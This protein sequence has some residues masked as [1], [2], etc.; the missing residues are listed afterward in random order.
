MYIRP[1]HGRSIGVGVNVGA[2]LG[3]WITATIERY[4]PAT[5]VYTVT[6]HLVQDLPHLVDFVK[7]KGRWRAVVMGREMTL[8][9]TPPVPV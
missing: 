5:L 2:D 6:F 4:D 8:R 9:G 3:G 7:S 1:E